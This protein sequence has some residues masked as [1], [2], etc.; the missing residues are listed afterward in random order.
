[1][2]FTN[3]SIIQDLNDV[4]IGC[5]KTTKPE[6]SYLE[7]K[8][9][10]KRKILRLVALE[11]KE[12]MSL[13]ISK[14][15]SIQEVADT[16]YS[17]LHISEK[18]YPLNEEEIVEQILDSA[19]LKNWDT[20]VYYNFLGTHEGVVTTKTPIEVGGTIENLKDEYETEPNLAD[21]LQALSSSYNT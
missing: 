16:V 6:I 4:I 14:A 12:N 15:A 11:V 13:G 5:V 3:P 20:E 19:Q 9:L 18:F 8:S 2:I 10:L 21:F 7:Y 1:M 17:Y